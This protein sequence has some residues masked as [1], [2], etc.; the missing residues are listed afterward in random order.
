MRVRGVP[1]LLMEDETRGRLRKLEAQ[2]IALRKVVKVLVT[3]VFAEHYDELRDL[4]ERLVSGEYGIESGDEEARQ[5]AMEPLK[6]TMVDAL[7]PYVDFPSA[8]DR[9]MSN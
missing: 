1:A 9:S 5:R 3:I 2:N 7:S 4:R 8:L 6:E